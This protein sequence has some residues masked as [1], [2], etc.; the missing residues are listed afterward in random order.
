MLEGD[1]ESAVRDEPILLFGR[2]LEEAAA[3]EPD[4]PTAMTLATVDAAGRPDARIVLLKGF[5]A[6]GFVFFTN[7]ESRKGSQLADRPAAALCFHWKSLAR[8]VRTD[9][10][11]APVTPAEAD[12]YFASR[13]RISQLGAWASRQSAPLATRAAQEA[14]L[15][16]RTAEFEGRE[17]PRPAHWSGFRVVPD[18]IEFWA[19]RPFRLH[20]RVEY[21]LDGDG[22][23]R[24]RL[25]P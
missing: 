14:E 9:G 11:V 15:A 17:V 23:R 22:W 16:M 1:H 25:F 7:F 19:D 5:D 13:P 10:T 4:N 12:E 24:G 3:K 21:R 8:Q 20:D 2:W 18:R 6:A